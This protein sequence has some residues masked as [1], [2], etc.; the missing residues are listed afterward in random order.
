MTLVG[1]PEDTLL[2][3]EAFV[4]E[5]IRYGLSTERWM[6]T[7]NLAWKE[8]EEEEEVR[9]DEKNRWQPPIWGQGRGRRHKGKHVVINAGESRMGSRRKVGKK[10]DSS[11]WGGL[12][13][14]SLTI[15]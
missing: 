7:R 11:I 4:H 2:L 3:D 13:Q 14:Y 15:D 12:Y 1:A 10:K 9:V 5:H 8:E 6:M